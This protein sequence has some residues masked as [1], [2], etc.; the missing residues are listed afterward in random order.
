EVLAHVSGIAQRHLEPG[1]LHELGPGGAVELVERRALHSRRGFHARS[2][3]VSKHGQGSGAL[4]EGQARVP[5]GFAA[6]DAARAITGWA[7]RRAPRVPVPPLRTPRPPCRC[8][9]P[10]ARPTAARGCAP[11][12][13]PRRGTRTRSRTRPCRAVARRGRARG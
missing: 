11:C 4:E 10:N 3:R 7:T 2:S 12:P 6:A 13:W 9:P 8:A 1:E 5:E